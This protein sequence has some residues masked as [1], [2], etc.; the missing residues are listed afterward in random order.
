MLF[1]QLL[2]FTCLLQAF[3]FCLPFLLRWLHAI[4]TGFLRAP[5]PSSRRYIW[6]RYN[7][8]SYFFGCPLP[9]A[10]FEHSD[11]VSLFCLGGSTPFQRGSLEPPCRLGGG[12]CGGGTMKQAISFG[13]PLPHA[14]FWHSISVSYSCRGGLTPSQQSSLEHPCRLQGGTSGV[15]TMKQAISSAA[16]FHMP[17]LGTPFLSPFSPEVASRHLN[18]AP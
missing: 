4:S 17:L 10:S 13:C 7:E 15:G 8:A 6:R 5:L 9:H 2:F 12:T 1:F 3:R 11:S 18:G 16:L 14:S